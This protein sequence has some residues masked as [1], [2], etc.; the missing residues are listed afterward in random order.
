MAQSSGEVVALTAVFTVLPI[1]FVVLRMLARRGRNLGI[2]A[3]DVLVISA[4][5]SEITSLY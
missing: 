1:F 5:V 4:T 3:D 2:G